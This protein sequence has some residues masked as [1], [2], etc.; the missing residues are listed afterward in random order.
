VFA[1]TH[2][3]RF[4]VPKK[5][6]AT[7]QAEVIGEKLMA[8][9]GD[10]AV[11]KVARRCGFL[12]RR[13]DVAPAALLVACL[14]ALGA[15][16]AMWLADILRAFNAF[17]GKA[18]RYKPFHNQISK[19]KFP[20][21]VHAILEELLAKLTAPVLVGVP[22]SKLAQFEEIVAH[23]G[24]SFALKNALAKKW[25]GR[26]KKLTP[27]AVELHVTMSVLSDNPVAITL[28]PDKE[29]ERRFSPKAASLKNRLLLEDRGYQEREFFVA[30]QDA[31]GSFI[32]RGTKSIRPTIRTARDSQGRRLRHLEGRRLSWSL[33]PRHDVDLD[34]NW[35]RD[36]GKTYSGR[37][38]VIYA[39]GK[40]NKATFVYLHTNLPRETFSAHDVG[41]IYRLRWQVELLFKEWKSHSNLHKFDTGKAPIAEG[42]IWA[43][44]LAATLRRCITHAAERACGIPLSTQRAARSAKHFLDAILAAVL[45]C[46]TSLI[47]DL[48][49]AFAFLVGNALRAHPKRDRKNGR[50]AAGLRHVAVA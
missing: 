35:K 25:P 19:P 39:E 50:L 21:F 15:G 23:D 14:S 49:A 22:R 48:R 8:V 2:A 20:N 24:T 26:F 10:G 16:A 38:V 45:E 3:R 36:S 6:N 12:R 27:A 29:A 43:S 9:L 33:L 4:P 37:L 17:T 44:L 30:V 7:T 13:R 34:I 46:S 32:V 18:V 41:Q 40:Q 31:D 5:D 47:D 11:E 1:K 28:A 42:L